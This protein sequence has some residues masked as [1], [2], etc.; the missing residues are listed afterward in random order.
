MAQC[1]ASQRRWHTPIV[2][3]GDLQ[4]APW[5]EW[6]LGNLEEPKAG[7]DPD[8][9]LVQLYEQSCGCSSDSQEKEGLQSE[10]VVWLPWLL[11]E[12]GI[13]SLPGRL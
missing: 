13:K 11:C 3:S 9:L 10:L 5:D 8:G 1:D 4:K 6:V 12:V 2:F 7:G